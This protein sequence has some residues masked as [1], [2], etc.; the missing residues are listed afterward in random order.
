MASA[1]PAAKA[2]HKILLANRGKE[3]LIAD[4]GDA[5]VKVVDTTRFKVGKTIALTPQPDSGI[6]DSKS[7]AFYIFKS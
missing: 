1:W 6:E 7:G 3:L 2:P 4:A 5:D